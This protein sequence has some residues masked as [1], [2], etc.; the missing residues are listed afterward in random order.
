MRHM[1]VAVEEQDDRIDQLLLIER[2]LAEIA[3]A[4]DAIEAKLHDVLARPL[5]GFTETE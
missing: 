3:A 1:A 5:G 2:E 4:L